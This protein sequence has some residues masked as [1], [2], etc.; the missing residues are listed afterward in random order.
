[1]EDNLSNQETSRPQDPWIVWGLVTLSLIVG[2]PFLGE[3]TAC[4]S[5][6]FTIPE[7]LTIAAILGTAGSISIIIGVIVG[8]FS[9]S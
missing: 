9:K 7:F 8:K 4:N 1:M 3:R 2:L 6:G 5:D